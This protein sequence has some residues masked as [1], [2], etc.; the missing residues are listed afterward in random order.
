MIDAAGTIQKIVGM[1]ISDDSFRWL[2]QIGIKV[3]KYHGFV[4][5][6]RYFYQK[7]LHRRPD[8][9]PG[10]PGSRHRH[11]PRKAGQPSQAPPAEG[12]AASTSVARG[13]LMRG[14]VGS[15][16][17]LVRGRRG[18]CAQLVRSRGGFCAQLV[19][20]GGAPAARF[21]PGAA[22]APVAW[23][24]RGRGAPA[25]RFHP[26]AAETGKS[27]PGAK[28]GP[29]F[30]PSAVAGRGSPPKKMH[31][32]RFRAAAIPPIGKALKGFR[33]AAIPPIGKAQKG[34]RAA[35][36]PPEGRP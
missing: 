36:I 5:R 25:T 31:C 3:R 33:A 1:F 10:R 13:R 21:H 35:A 6:R 34:F 4:A 18:F 27:R 24:R 23:L 11:L 32:R 2:T 26:G 7:K 14:R 17:R 8:A 9:L 29:G 15:V 22:E 28:S 20:D 12:R 19:R 16:A 30:H